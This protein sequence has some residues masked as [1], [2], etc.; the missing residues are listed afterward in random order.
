MVAATKGTREFCCPPGRHDPSTTP[1]RN[2]SNA[3]PH[4]QCPA[5]FTREFRPRAAAF[6]PAGVPAPQRALRYPPR[7][8]PC[9]P[10]AEDFCRACSRRRQA[11]ASTRRSSTAPA[12]SAGWSASSAGRTCPT[13]RPDAGCTVSDSRP[14]AIVPLPSRT[15]RRRR[16]HDAGAD[17]PGC[18]EPSALRASRASQNI[19]DWWGGRSIREPLQRRRILSYFPDYCNH[20]SFQGSADMHRASAGGDANPGRSHPT[21][22][23]FV[24]V[25]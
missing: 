13:G 7:V 12:C 21:R 9:P 16:P 5:S 20:W 22:S 19:C 25:S 18:M 23:F 15:G 8:P 6:I 17:G 11:L 24:F 14:A 10:K 4:P 3:F 2:P 1:K